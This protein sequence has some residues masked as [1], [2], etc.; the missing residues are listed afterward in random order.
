MQILA[1]V[2]TATRQKPVLFVCGG[3]ATDLASA[4]LLDRSTAERVILVVPTGVKRGQWWKL[5]S[6]SA[7]IVLEHFRCVFVNGP[8]L[9]VDKAHVQRIPDPR[10]GTLLR[11]EAGS[12]RDFCMLALLS[13]RDDT[14]KVSR[15]RFAGF[16][17]ERPTYKSDPKG[18][19]WRIKN[20]PEKPLQQ[21]FDRVFLSQPVR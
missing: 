6:W 20:Q 1:A 8:V 11:K 18:S 5:D 7:G 13:V 4:W 10:W 3:A 16:H 9:T 15:V 21:E 14:R 12:D 17:H 19:I 2:Q